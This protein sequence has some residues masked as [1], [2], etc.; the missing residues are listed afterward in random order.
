[1]CCLL[2]T[3]LLDD[4]NAL[5]LVRIGLLTEWIGSNLDTNGHQLAPHNG[6]VFRM[7]M[8][9]PIAVGH[10]RSVVPTR[11][12]AS[13]Q[14]NACSNGTGRSEQE[15][16]VAIDAIHDAVDGEWAIR[17]CIV[18]RAVQIAFLSQRNHVTQDIRAR[19]KERE[20]E[21]ESVCVCV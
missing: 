21:R 20:R 2:A 18:L 4:S 11:P 8:H 17:W 12:D 3:D 7:A 5:S 15:L 16:D 13:V 14:Q 10:V 9:A 19:G 6:N 1:V